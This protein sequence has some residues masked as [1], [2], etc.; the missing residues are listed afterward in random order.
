MTI[1]EQT[2]PL[3][4]QEECEELASAMLSKYAAAVGDR[5]FSIE[6]SRKDRGV[7]VSVVLANQDESF[8]YP[9]EGRILAEVEEMTPR[10]AALVLID[11]ID[12]YF[13]E[14]LMEE[15][16]GLYLPID[17]ADH[18]WDAVNFQLRGQILNRKLERLA[19]ELL[20]GQVT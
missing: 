4:S 7:Y 9:V 8:Y 20:S 18:E 12:M 6:V 15:E 2:K 19:D 10:Q 3:V 16:D 13:E 5:Q 1:S 17:W 14:F 11:Y